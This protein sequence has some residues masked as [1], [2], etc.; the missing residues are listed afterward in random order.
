MERVIVTGA[1]GFVGARLAELLSSRGFDVAVPCRATSRTDCMPD[2][3]AV[4]RIEFLRPSSLEGVMQG[5]SAVYHVAG[6][7]AASSQE[8]FDV[9]NAAVTRSLVAARDACAPDATFVYL[10]S[11]SASGPG[12]GGPITAY[13]RSKLLAE[14]VVKRSRN[15]VIV[16][17]P[18][19]FGPGDESLGPLFRIAARGFLPFPARRGCG[20]SMIQVDDLA[21]MLAALQDCPK[22]LGSVL[23]PS[24][25][26]VFSWGE[27]RS[28]LQEASGVGIL[29]VPVPPPLVRMAGLVSETIG[30]FSGRCHV[31]DR[32]KAGEFLA[33]GWSASGQAAV[34]R[35]TGWRPS[36]D[37]GAALRQAWEYY[38]PGRVRT[39]GPAPAGPGKPQ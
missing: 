22:A 28:L 26:R 17:P 19:V 25:G 1:S 39:A 12:G 32:Q 31:F 33:V 36:G 29:P 20:F 18:V 3:C 21:E 11:Q 2:G 14:M 6:A 24:Y 34:E 27:F 10:S 8:G 4:S 38:N 7:V 15:W 16:R 30:T 23:E 13:G 5:A 35:A 9:A 37:P